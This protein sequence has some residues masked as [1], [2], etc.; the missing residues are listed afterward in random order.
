MMM[1][2][3]ISAVLTAFAMILI[4]SG[5]A[6]EIIVA[7]VLQTPVQAQIRTAYN[8]W[9]E[10][11]TEMDT[12]NMQKGSI[13]PFGT[14]VEVTKASDK[15][16]CFTTVDDGKKFRIEYEYK[17]RL[18]TPEEILK[19]VFTTRT[20]EDLRGN[21]DALTYEKVRRGIVEKGMTRQAVLLAYGPPCAIRTPDMALSSWLYPLDFLEYKR[22]IFKDNKIIEILLP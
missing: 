19:T 17:Y 5:C 4:L 7:E 8:L 22:L 6:R 16:I 18:Q 14:V 1:M 2:K 9:Y 12:I 3:K 10:N 20:E 11:P 15:E 13:I 21:L